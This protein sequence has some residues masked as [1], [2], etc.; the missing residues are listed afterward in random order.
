MSIRQRLGSVLADRLQRSFVGRDAELAKLERLIGP[1]GDGIGATDVASHGGISGIVHRHN[2]MFLVGVFLTDDRP[3]KQ[4]S[5]SLDFSKREHVHSLAPGI[6][7][8]FLIGPRAGHP[9]VPRVRRR[10]PLSGPPGWCGNNVG[11]LEVTV[12]LRPG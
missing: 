8:T 1:A 3:G 12:D 9:P 7:Q 2:G 11:E 4:A 10:L 5:P 6:A